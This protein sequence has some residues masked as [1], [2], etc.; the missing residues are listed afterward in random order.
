MSRTRYSSDP[1]E[2]LA[3]ALL[4][5]APRDV[6]YPAYQARWERDQSRQDQQNA[7]LL[8]ILHPDP[9]MDAVKL[10]RS[11]EL[12]LMIRLARL[13]VRQSEIIRLYREGWS[14]EEM[15]RM[16]GVSRQAVH[17]QFRSACSAIRSVWRVHPLRGLSVVY[18]D[19]T[20]HRFLVKKRWTNP[21]MR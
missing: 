3:D 19:E 4:R 17:K 18:S 15:A 2:D 13:S 21:E 6:E 9:R 16:W 10:V 7:P 1:L 14:I 20:S 11:H 12:E 5:S 8:G